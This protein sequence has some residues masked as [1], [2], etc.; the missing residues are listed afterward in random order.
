MCVP[1]YN[2]RVAACPRL[3]SILKQLYL[4]TWVYPFPGEHT[5]TR[6]FVP[7]IQQIVGTTGSVPV[8]AAQIVLGLVEWWSVKVGLDY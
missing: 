3:P 6:F 1:K 4:T 8:V 2:L 7:P 5:H